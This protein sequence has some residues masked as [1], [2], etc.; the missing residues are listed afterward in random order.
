MK[1]RNR[2]AWVVVAMT[3]TLA[4]TL[5]NNIAHAGARDWP[6]RVGG[7]HEPICQKALQVAQENF[8]STNV[9]FG[10]QGGSYSEGTDDALFTEAPDPTDERTNLS[11]QT[12]PYQGHRVV[13]VASE[14][15]GDTVYRAGLIRA[16]V[17]MPE[18]YS[19]KDVMVMPGGGSYHGP[20]V[21]QGEVPGKLGLVSPG[22]PFEFLPTWTVYL[23]VEGQFQEACKIQFRKEVKQAPLLLP[24]PV[25]RLATLLDRSIGRDDNSFGTYHSIT[26][27]KIEASQAWANAALRPWVTGT[28]Y[29]SREEVDTGLATWAQSHAWNR[30]LHADIVAQYKR[31]EKALATYY[32]TQFQMPQS[33]SQ[34]TAKRIL[35]IAFRTYYIFHKE[36]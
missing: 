33:E 27:Q 20:L 21:L 11:W 5:A 36:G 35:D 24:S 22:E 30:A 23:T 29:N 12:Q 25:Q 34:A 6:M 16:E 18:S 15:R 13:I 4:S 17:Q 10:T 26:R 9:K 7:T 19:E 2:T 14:W 32:R 1:H 3:A 31:A 8:K 28:P